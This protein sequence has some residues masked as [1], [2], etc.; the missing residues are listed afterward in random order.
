MLC[1]LT[2]LLIIDDEIEGFAGL[3][4]RLFS[5]GNLLFDFLRMLKH[6]LVNHFE[7]DY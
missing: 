5:T 4:S 7:S 6:L 1:L 3:G 2:V